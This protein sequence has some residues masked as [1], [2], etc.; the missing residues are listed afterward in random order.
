MPIAPRCRC[1]PPRARRSRRSGRSQR[2][3]PRRAR[4]RRRACRRP[5]ACSSRPRRHQHGANTS[6]P[7]R[8]HVVAHVADHVEHCE[9][10]RCARA[11][12][13]LEQALPALAAHH[14]RE[15]VQQHR[16][17]EV[18]PFAGRAR[19]LRRLLVQRPPTTPLS[20]TAQTARPDH[21]ARERPRRPGPAGGCSGGRSAVGVGVLVG[22]ASGE[23]SSSGRARA[24]RS[25][26]CVRAPSGSR[27]D[28][29][30]DGGA[31]PLRSRPPAPLRAGPARVG[32]AFRWSPT[33]P[34]R[35]SRSPSH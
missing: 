35:R 21:V 3:P 1:R 13:V 14:R 32:A 12:F 18:G 9:S 19:G 23:S 10:T 15:R 26:S 4:G 20:A 33:T 27:R 17:P 24:G 16:Q 30:G 31:A 29:V 28:S 11:P 34:S 25:R 8:Q 7:A 6:P 2:S 5:S 22:V